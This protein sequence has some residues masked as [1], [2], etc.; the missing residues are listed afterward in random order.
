MSKPVLEWVSQLDEDQ[1]RLLLRD[2]L[3]AMSYLRVTITHGSLE[4]GRDLVFLEEDRLKR[5]VWRA[6]Q[7]KAGKLSGS[8][9]SGGLATAI[10]QCKAALS[11]K[12]RPASGGE[13]VIQEVWLVTNQ[14][15]SDQARFSV[16]A[17]LQ[18]LR[19]VVLIDGAHLTDLVEQYLPQM[20]AQQGLPI[21]H[22]LEKLSEYCDSVENYIASQTQARFSLQDVFIE[23][24][25]SIRFLSAP[26]I[27]GDLS[28]AVLVRYDQFSKALLMA[29][30]LSD[31]GVLPALA[32]FQITSGLQTLEHFAESLDALPLPLLTRSGGGDLL[33]ALGELR[34]VVAEIN[35]SYAGDGLRGQVTAEML[36]R[37]ER[38]LIIAESALTRPIEDYLRLKGDPAFAAALTSQVRHRI[39]VN[40]GQFFVAL[41]AA[42]N[43]STNPDD[44]FTQL[45]IRAA[46]ALAETVPAS[47]NYDAVLSLCSRVDELLGAATRSLQGALRGLSEL[48]P[49]S[50][51]TVEALGAIG[52]RE[53]LTQFI[54]TFWGTLPEGSVSRLIVPGLELPELVGRLVV[55]ADLGQGKTTLLK[56]IGKKW[57]QEYLAHNRQSLPVL[58]GLTSLGAEATT[59]LFQELRE[60][61][62]ERTPALAQVVPSEIAW[63][64][65]G[66]DEVKAESKRLEI[67]RWLRSGD[68]PARV[69]MSSRPGA[70]RGFLPRVL[71]A[72]LEPLGDDDIGRLVGKFSWR[73]AKDGERLTHV[74]T[75][76]NAFRE[77]ARNPLLLTLVIL[78]AQSRGVED[79]PTRRE[80]LFDA[81]VRLFLGEWDTQKRDRVEKL[82]SIPGQDEKKSF[83]KTRGIQIVRSRRAIIH[84]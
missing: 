64:L 44:P 37:I 58:C 63:L 22:Y 39:D 45:A 71:V 41:R 70:L 19:G 3:K 61:A 49:P 83:A 42:F 26:A 55:V 29:T 84:G 65:D 78:V 53:Q 10:N 34:A 18:D 66:L 21:E 46:E 4:R 60:V 81:I 48:A 9:G 27:A 77:I 14:P 38:R 74:L 43:T 12:Y 52:E 72:R 80:G 16:E 11:N 32:Q 69:V 15:L 79:L 7:A 68:A 59:E 36:V 13:V 2:L 50:D 35:S 47:A 51:L 62:R 57:S 73:D 82:Y 75:S 67:L 56:Q 30:R 6:V 25:L 24:T 8:Y 54:E 28:L 20:I 76:T 1:L 40:H 31:L 33:A 5:H 23:P 17:E